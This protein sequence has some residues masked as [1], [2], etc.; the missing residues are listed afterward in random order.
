MIC[1]CCEHEMASPSEVEALRYARLA[2]Q[3]RIVLDE[4]VRA[5]PKPARISALIN[6]LYGDDPDGGADNPG[7]VIRVRVMQLRRVLPRYGWDIPT[8]KGGRGHYGEY[9]LERL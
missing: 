7:Q 1:P 9:R 6:A 3:E 5:Y 8:A 2:R 4:L